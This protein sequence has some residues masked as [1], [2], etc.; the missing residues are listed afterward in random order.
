[1]SPGGRVRA[2]LTAAT[3][4]SLVAATGGAS[5]Q[6]LERGRAVYEKWC[7]ECHGSDGRGDGPAAT[8]MLPRPRDF[9]QARYQIRTTASGE[10]PTDDDISRVLLRGMPGT[11]MPAW[12]NLDE[13]ERAD[14]LAYVKSFSPFFE[15]A[16]P[17]PMAF[18]GDPG[19]G[20]AALS[21]GSEV[22]DKLECWKCHGA[23]G[24]GNGQSTPTLEDW[25]KLPIRAADLTEPWVFNGGMGVEAIHTRFLTGLDGTPMPAYSDA[26]ESGIVSDRDLWDLAHYVHSLGPG[27]EP[28]VRELI[29]AVRVAGVLPKG[30]GDGGWAEA[31]AFYVPLVGQVVLKPRQFSP[32][33]DGVWVRAF[34]DGSELA[35]LLTWND[36][37]R[38]PDPDWDEWQARLAASLYADGEEPVTERRL[39]DGFVVQFPPSIPEGTERPYFL[40]GNAR[41]PVIVWN[42][43]S[44]TGA[45]EL[46]AR[47]LGAME[48]LEA[49]HLRGVASY[50]DGQW[51]LQ[52]RRALDTGGTETLAFREGT[53]IPVAFFAWDGSS[54]EDVRRGSVSG[55]Y[56]IHLAEPP[57]PMAYAAPLIAALVTGALGLLVVAR[58]QK[59]ELS[60]ADAVAQA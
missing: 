22:Y 12:D 49:N 13:K 34:H 45:S 3:A 35:M 44:Q 47:G 60:R 43:E 40:M 9:V 6:D 46:R 26:L 20:T 24:R 50:D 27:K 41:H 59:R 33:V 48:A 37:S 25:R 5:G 54:A 4:A 17:E 2:M 28:T 19:G 21:A 18:T 29:E 58:A 51:R 55:W 23:S 53:P 38:S 30:P 16:P 32:T 10:L 52:L 15:D 42:W 7:V 39:S 57:S 8:Y 11:T 14:V 1:L 31:E 36:P 56:F